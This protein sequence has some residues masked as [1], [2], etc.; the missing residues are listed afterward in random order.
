[1]ASHRH[2]HGIG[3]YERNECKKTRAEIDPLDSAMVSILEF[4]NGDKGQASRV[5][6]EVLV[7]AFSLL[8]SLAHL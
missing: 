3:K 5:I 2:G 4:V 8:H 1:M 7:F 6:H